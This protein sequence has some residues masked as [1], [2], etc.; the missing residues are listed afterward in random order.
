MDKDSIKTNAAKRRIAK[1]C[2]NSIWRKLTENPK[3][4]QTILIFDPQESY[5]FLATTS[6]EFSNLLFAGNVLVWISWRHIEETRAPN[7]RH[8]NEVIVSY[9]TAGARL[10]LYGYVEK[11]KDRAIYCDT[12]SVVYIQPTD[13]PAL[14][15][16]GDCL[17]AMTSELKT[18]EIISKFVCG[19]PKNYVYKIF[20]SVTSGE[21]TVCKVRE[22][23]MNYNAS[24][25]VNFDKN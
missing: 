10:H 16:I 24:Q 18:N 25:L 13:G 14:V 12:D 15:E 7:L 6:I 23:T 11:L 8:T 1:L 19:G 2:L 22:I 9:V 3:K 20:N 21:Q 4:T 17:G 5:R